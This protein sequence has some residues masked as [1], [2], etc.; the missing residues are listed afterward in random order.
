MTMPLKSLAALLVFGLVAVSPQPG[1]AAQQAAPTTAAA[2]SRGEVLAAAERLAKW[3]LAH[4]PTPLILPSGIAPERAE[5]ARL[6]QASNPWSWHQGTFWLGMTALADASSSPWAR[7][8]ILDHGRAASWQPGPRIHHAD[9]QLIGAS[10]I[11]AAAHGAGGGALQPLRERLDRIL[12]DPPQA[13][14]AMLLGSDET[15]GHSSAEALK[16][17]SWADALFMAPPVW[18][19]LA[20]ETGDRRY[21][22][23]AL[24]EFWAANDFLYDPAERLYFRDSRFF[25]K[26]DEQ[27]R[28]IF[29]SRGNGWV[30]AALAQMI[31]A[32]PPGDPDRRRLENQFRGFAGR[33]VALQKPDGYWPSSLLASEDTIPE[34]SGTALFTYG[35]AWGIG[36]GLLP[37][38]A[39]EHAVRRGW[40][41]LQASIQPDGSLG[42][43]QPAGDRPAPATAS[44][45]QV[46]ATGAY[47]LAATAIADL[48]RKR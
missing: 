6:T 18:L 7:R 48:D 13:H 46:Y 8:A 47:L 1:A 22:D 44:G 30:I 23:Y 42:W 21:R 29:W 4:M 26:R 40:Q 27:G 39:Y 43:V 9:D 2:P 33:V 31:D 5:L 24:R 34:S 10:Y 35:L 45:T 19:R 20:R 17:W 38:G 12:A 14:L 11:W 32:L 3:Q 16:R 25:D 37:R 41:A 36:K 15:R 28:K